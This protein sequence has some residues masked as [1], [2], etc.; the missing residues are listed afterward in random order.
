MM[1]V[2]RDGNG[3]KSGDDYLVDFE[4]WGKNEFGAQDAI[5]KYVSGATKADAILDAG[6]HSI[7]FGT[8]FNDPKALVQ[9]YDELTQ[10]RAEME[11]T[12]S[13]KDLADS[14][15]YAETVEWLT[16]M[17]ETVTEYKGHLD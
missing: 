8:D 11:S 5:M 6:V 12:M 16:R 15:I 14:G 1:D 3:R 17:E 2:A 7:S 10:A 13:Q 4:G 9:L